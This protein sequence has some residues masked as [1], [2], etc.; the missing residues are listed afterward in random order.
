MKVRIKNIKKHLNSMPV[1][2]LY[3]F[4]FFLP[5]LQKIS[6]VCIFMFG[7]SYI[8]WGN[9]RETFDNLSNNKLL[10]L[11]LLFYFIHL[12]GLIYTTN[13]NYAFSDLETKSS[14]LFIPLLLL[15]FKPGSKL[16]IKL[17]T[18]FIYGNVFASSVCLINSLISYLNVREADVFFY[19]KYSFFLHPTY[20]T[21]YLNLSLLLVIKRY[22]NKLILPLAGNFKYLL[23]ILF[24]FGNI[25]F[26]T[27]RA[28][29]VITLL[30][31][32]GYLIY[33]LL[34]TRKYR[35]K[36]FIHIIV[37]LILFFSQLLVLKN[38]NR[39]SYLKY[40]VIAAEKVGGKTKKYDS[41]GVTP[42]RVQ[43]WM[44][45]IE[46]IKLHPIFGVGTGDLKDE[47]IRVYWEREGI[48]LNPHNQ[49]LQTAA[50]LGII[51]L[52]ILLAM[53][54]FP[55]HDALKKRY[56]MFILFIAIILLNAVTESILER[57]AG[58]VFFSFFYTYFYLAMNSDHSGQFEN[59]RETDLIKKLKDV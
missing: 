34:T 48:Y 33:L 58:I 35:G 51:G 30:T 24:L 43:L 47:L 44:N 3:L 40:E 56:P 37:I 36:Y 42:T 54:T 55:V 22:F 53:L 4:I 50:S 38:F 59:I 27:S 7:I 1:L 19:E 49:Y 46:V 23:L 14:L 32:L 10:A 39:F 52:C 11:P 21:I 8:M 5:S 18:T 31:S 2:L 16:L 57:Q 15:S 28:G 13:Y 41:E 9:L 45:A 6:I 25:T 29:I 12:F 17:E 26:L 20:F